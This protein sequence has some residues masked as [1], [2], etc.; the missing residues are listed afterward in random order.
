MIRRLLST[1]AFSSAAAA[2]PPR[3]VHDLR[4]P[5]LI[6][7]KSVLEQNAA[8]MLERAEALGCVLRPHVK[9]VKTAE[10]AALATGGTRRRLVC[11]T[12][13]EA[14]FL[15]Q[16]D[17]DDI[18]YAVPLTPDKLPEV[19]ALHGSLQ[20]FHVMVDHADHV[21]AL[22]DESAATMPDRRPLSVFVG[23]DCGYHRDGV[24]PADPASVELVRQLCESPRTSFSG[25]YTHGGHSYDTGGDLEA[26]ARVATAER[27]VTVRFAETL[28]AAGLHVPSVGVGSTPTCSRPPSDGLDGVDE[29]HPGNYLYYDVT[30][31]R[32]GS[33][34]VDQI[35]VRVLTRVVGHYPKS[36]TLLVDCGWTGASAQ[37][38][39]AGYGLF[40][41]HPELTIQNLKQE[42]GEVSS[43][44]GRALDFC[45]YPIGSLLELAPWH[46]CAST[47]QHRSVHIVEDDGV[48]VSDEWEV[49]K[50]W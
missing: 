7:Y 13:A 15:A 4:T 39:E 33:C 27:D 12:L 10:G 34:T 19:R 45:R 40:P 43:T 48:S 41:K 5:C 26:L 21:S 44:D 47:H 28:R 36:N 20:S 32:L 29:M 35:A 46:S 16:H 11:S 25:V 23:V 17:F 8:A 22:T 37:G 14:S 6:C 30:Q 49:C 24:D 1:A 9:T 38:A 42:C 18:L 3:A 31:T 50:G 2:T